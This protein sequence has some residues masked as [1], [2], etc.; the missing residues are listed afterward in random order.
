MELISLHSRDIRYN[1][2][3]DLNSTPRLG[4][5]LMPVFLQFC[6]LVLGKIFPWT[7]EECFARAETRPAS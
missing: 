4:K 7:G 6:A 1:N 5:E 2:F 3:T